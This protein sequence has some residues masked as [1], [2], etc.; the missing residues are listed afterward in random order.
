MTS[1]RFFVANPKAEQSTFFAIVLLNGA[2]YKKGL[3]IRV[4]P[5][6]WDVK[7]QRASVSQRYREGA[8]VN[9]EVEQ[10]RKALDRLVENIRTGKAAPAD[11]AGFWKLAECEKEG[12]AYETAGATTEYLSEYL[13]EVFIPRFRTSKSHTR[14]VRFGVVLAK[15]KEFEASEGQRFKFGEVDISF[16]RRF[17]E[18]MNR[19]NHSANY[20]GTVVKVIKQVMREAEI[21][22]KIHTNEQYKHSDFRATT[23]E[24]DTVYL[25]TEELYRIHAT[26]I[27]DAF[28]NRFYPRADGAA[29]ESV[30]QSYTIVKNRFLIGAFTGLRMSDFNRVDWSNIRDGMI[31]MITQKTGQKVVIPVHPVVREIIDGGFDMSRSLSEAKTRLYI[32][33]IC[34]Y[35]GIGDV[36]EVRE[37]ENGRLKSERYEKWRLVGTHTARRSFATNAFKAG[38]PVISI[39]KITGHKKEGEFMKYIRI[40]QEENAELLAKHPFFSGE[41]N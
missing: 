20:F 8:A 26:P 13:E 4:V 38:V 37:E 40:S 10:W 3:G 39:M 5:K 28:A 41:N 6:Y 36:V 11:N 18:Y 33:D 21:I 32:K 22:D 24:V 19:L 17:Q 29:R 12:R 31:T 7:A 27:D 23:R 9:F 15:L 30:I 16:Y 25:T 2:R 14:I 34:R 1:V 35:A